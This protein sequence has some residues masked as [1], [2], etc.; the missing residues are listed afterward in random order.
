MSGIIE[1][2][3]N[4]IE[5]YKKLPQKNCGVCRQRAC[6]PFA[7]SVIKGDAQLSDCPLLS[8]SEIDDLKGKITLADWREDL[9]RSLREK[10]SDIN[11][12]EISRDLG[13]R[14]QNDLLIMPCL[15]REFEISPDGEIRSSGPITPWTK[16]LLLHYINTRG[17]AILSGKW[18]SYGELKSGMVKASSF[19]RDCEDPLKEL[20]DA[21]TRKT[22]ATLEKMGAARSSEFPTPYAWELYLLPRMPVIIL[23]WPEEDEFPSKVKILFDQTADRF[24]DA[25][26]IMFLLEGLVKNIEMLR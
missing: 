10:I 9:I 4:A 24:L 11:L 21:D 12:Q 7:L 2:H 16:I 15:G 25:E 20:F 13:G 22:T 26:S 17:K 23:Y 3:M 14:M 8:I 19:R 5:L 1:I 6:M 18:V